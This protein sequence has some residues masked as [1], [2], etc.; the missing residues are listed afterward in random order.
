MLI[1]SVSCTAHR[2]FAELSADAEAVPVPSGVTFVRQ[3]QEMSNGSEFTT[4]K[5]EQVIRQYGAKMPCTLLEDN[6]A[7]AL[8][9]AGRRFK[10][11]NY[12]HKFG[13]IGSLEI[14]IQDR[15]ELLG[16][17]IGTDDGPCPNPI[18][19]ASNFPH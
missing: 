17:N 7:Q 4:T 3:Q 12:P 9:A 1:V 11:T 2:T 5:Y 16:I 13:A 10:I 18:V 6:W 15:P 8:R 19:Y 14:E